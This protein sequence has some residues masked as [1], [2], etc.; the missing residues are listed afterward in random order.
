MTILRLRQSFGRLIG[1]V[2]YEY[3]SQSKSGLSYLQTAKEIG[4]H[5]PNHTNY[6]AALKLKNVLHELVLEIGVVPLPG[7]ML[8]TPAIDPL[9]KSYP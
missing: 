2:E 5:F 7:S 6:F 1:T 9:A 3:E 8:R 4:M